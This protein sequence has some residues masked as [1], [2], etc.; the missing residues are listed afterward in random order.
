MFK[1]FL[2]FPQI[3]L[4]DQPHRGLLEI[5]ADIDFWPKNKGKGVRTRNTEWI[6]LKPWCTNKKNFFLGKDLL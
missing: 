2:G 1:A 4:G 6:S 5:P 3:F